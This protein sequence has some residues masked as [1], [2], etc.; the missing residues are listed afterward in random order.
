MNIKSFLKNKLCKIGFHIWQ[1]KFSSEESWHE[2]AICNW[3]IEF[4]K[5]E[6]DSLRSLNKHLYE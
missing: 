5:E 3:Q 2:C 6:Y 1:D 4:S